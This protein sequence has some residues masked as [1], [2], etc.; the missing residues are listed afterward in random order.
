[1]KPK[2]H[3]KFPHLIAVA[4][5]VILVSA[6]AT[7]VIAGNAPAKEQLI[8]FVQGGASA[9][10]SE[11]RENNLPEIRKIAQEMD[12]SVQVFDAR[13][14]A[15]PEVTLTPM[16]VYQNH[17][18]RSI[19]QG[20]THTYDRIRNFIRTS[21]FVPQ[22]ETRL[23]REAIPIWRMGRERVWAPLKVSA[24]TGTQPPD[25]DNDMFQAEALGAIEKGFTNFSTQETADLDRADRGFY[26]DFYPWLSQDGTLYLSLALYSQ[27]HCKEPIFHTEEQPI[28]GPWKDRIKYFQQ[29]AALMEAEVEKRIKDPLGGDGFDAVA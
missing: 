17:L 27:F 9:L 13:D 24:V 19:Y 5:F 29:A 15:P 28:V 18:G 7:G 4:I 14:G 22:G 1:M 3:D 6:F 2:T 16:V 12:V 8:V 20:R 25:Y 10:D 26:M 11:F 23:K 21:R